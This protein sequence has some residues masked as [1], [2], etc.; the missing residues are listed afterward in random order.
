[1]KS[2]E[3]QFSGF[4]D[5]RPVPEHIPFRASRILGALKFGVADFATVFGVDL[6]SLAVF[7]MA[8]SAVLL[9]DLAVRVQDLE[10]TTPTWE[11]FREPWLS[12]NC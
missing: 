9:T 2:I 4:S 8:I 3:N 6:R 5:S 7:R 11:S 10:L 12:T 1:M